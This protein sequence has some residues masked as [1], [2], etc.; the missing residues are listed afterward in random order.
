[1]STLVARVQ[2]TMDSSAADLAWLSLWLVGWPIMMA[3]V[4]SGSG[5]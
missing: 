2:S 5:T 3:N 4:I 1:M